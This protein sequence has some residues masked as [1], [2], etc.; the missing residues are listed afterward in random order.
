ML[1]EIEPSYTCATIMFVLHSSI[2]QQISTVGTPSQ[3]SFQ[4]GIEM[5]ETPQ[6]M[7]PYQGSFQV[8]MQQKSTPTTETPSQ[9]SFEVRDS[10]NAEITPPAQ[11]PSPSISI[12]TYN[13]TIANAL[14]EG[15]ALH[16][17]M[18]NNG[19]AAANLANWKLVT[20]NQNLSYTFPIF[21]LMPKAIVT[22]HTH[23]G[24]NAVSDLYGSNFIWDGTH[25]IK[26]LD[27]NGMLIYDY[28]IA[29]P[30]T[31]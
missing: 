24:T 10:Q 6:T 8:G 17:L 9:T 25:D 4:E 16:V 22:I 23:N 18:A 14:K 26:L 11:A 15:E 12:Q 7:T 3:E 13:I 21:T 2:A 1:Y 31:K 27:N 29:T 20:D 5:G 19:T 28:R 30:S